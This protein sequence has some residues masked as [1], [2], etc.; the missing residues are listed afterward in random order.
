M[1]DNR[2][3]GALA[4]FETPEALIE[5][6]RHTRREGYRD[7][8]AFTPF[9]VKELSKILRLRDP[10]VP[11]LA[12]WGACFGAALALAMQFYTN[13]SYPINVGG[14]PIYALSAFAVVTFELTVLFGALAAAFG[15]LTLNRLPRL[16]DPVFSGSRFHLASR[17][18][19]FLYVGGSDSHFDEKA[20][21][22]FLEQLGACSVE[23]LP[24]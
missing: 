3:Y 8:D 2:C 13:W 5:A 10:R 15:M 16:H 17:D 4:E 1:A 21:P 12:F 7:L 6:A 19:F 23:V 11:W 20:T 18:R 24:L 22:R 14:R 9:P